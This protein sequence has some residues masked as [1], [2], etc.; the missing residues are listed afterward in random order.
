MKKTTG[1]SLVE[2]IITIVIVA[3]LASAGVPIYRGYMKRGI[4]TEAK[5]L[6]GQVNSA[7]QIYYERHSQ[8][9]AGSDEQQK[10]AGCFVDAKKNKYFT[11][12]SV[13]TTSANKF[14][15]VTNNYK[16]QQLTIIASR[17]ETP[18]MVEQGAAAE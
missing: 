11:S 9:Y 8:Y 16:G 1:F 10:E 3:I 18:T 15:A 17:D 6:L 13:S 5:T 12:Y 14:Q 2:L 7:Q 4:A